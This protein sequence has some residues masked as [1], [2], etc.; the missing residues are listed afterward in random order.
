[1]SDDARKPDRAILTQI[2]VI[3]NPEVW[4]QYSLQSFM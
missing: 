3:D 2:F 4:W 1:M